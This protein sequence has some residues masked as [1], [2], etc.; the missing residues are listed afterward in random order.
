MLIERIRKWIVDFG[1]T[2]GLSLMLS[3]TGLSQT[4]EPE[5]T[6][7]LFIGENCTRHCWFEL[8]TSDSTSE[9]VYEW[10]LTSENACSEATG[11]SPIDERI[12]GERDPETNILVDGTYEF[13][14]LP[15]SV[16]ENFQVTYAPITHSIRSTIEIVDG[17]ISQTHI[18]VWDYITFRDVIDSL[19]EPDQI[20]FQYFGP[21][22]EVNLQFIYIERRLRIN[23]TTRYTAPLWAEEVICNISDFLED[24]VL[25]N[26]NYLSTDEALET[27]SITVYEETSPALLWYGEYH[28]V[29]FDVWDT[30]LT[31]DETIPCRDAYFN[32]PTEHIYPDLSVLEAML[33]S[34][35]VP[36]D[37]E[38]D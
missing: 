29:P 6:G 34:T 36:E 17:V 3:V 1:M 10:L 21:G 25:S 28:Y 14:L 24:S 18:R 26:V 38:S 12:M 32:L 37:D 31:A 19:G 9:E 20:R 8:L 33:E 4:P 13:L 27:I 11:C 2:F 5:D 30:W 35:P 16:R 15:D 22:D 7:T 23:F